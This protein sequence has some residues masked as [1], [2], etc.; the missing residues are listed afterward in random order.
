MPEEDSYAPS[1]VLTIIQK[2]NFLITTNVLVLLHTISHNNNNLLNTEMAR[3]NLLKFEQ[4]HVLEFETVARGHHIY[5]SMLMPVVGEKL[6]CHH[7]TRD[8]AKLHDDYAI[9]I[10]KPIHIAMKEKETLV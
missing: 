3:A 7:D 6:N 8:E 2:L 4:T 10:Y 1:K 9:G 5:K